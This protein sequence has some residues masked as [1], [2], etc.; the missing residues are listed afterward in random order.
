LSYIIVRSFS[1]SIWLSDV[2]ARLNGV[3]GDGDFFIVVDGCIR[4]IEEK[5][6]AIGII[7]SCEIPVPV[8]LTTYGVNVET[9]GSRIG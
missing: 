5:S 8:V 7:P 3:K 1:D 4:S 6:D 2:L 9:V